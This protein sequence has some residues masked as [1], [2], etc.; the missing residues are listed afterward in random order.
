MLSVQAPVQVYLVSYIVF[1]VKNN[2]GAEGIGNL[3]KLAENFP[4]N[5]S[6][7]EDIIANRAAADDDVPGQLID[8][9][10]NCQN[11]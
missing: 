3:R 7:I 4:K 10:F 1:V 2:Q 9:Y 6:S 8:Y 5:S 11:Y